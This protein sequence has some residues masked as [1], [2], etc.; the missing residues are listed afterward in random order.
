MR[1]AIHIFKKDVRHFRFEIALVISLV[2][3]FTLIEMR[4]AL[5]LLDPGTDEIAPLVFVLILLPISWWTL[6]G[7][8][9]HDEALAG[10]RQFW[11]TRPYSWRSL[12]VAKML[13]A[14]VFINFPMLVADG[15]ILRAYGFSV[16]AVLSGL[17][18][19]Q[20]LLIIVFLLPII[21]LSTL[22]R[23]FIQLIIAILA[24]W[25][26]VLTLGTFAPHIF[27]RGFAGAFVWIKIYFALLIISAAASAILFWQYS[28][29]GTAFARSL[30][31]A[32]GVLVVVGITLIPWTAGFRI[33]SWLS[34]TPANLS[35]AHAVLDLD[36]KGLAR[37]FPFRGG[38]NSVGVRI[39][40]QIVGL[41]EGMT[42]KIQNLSESF[43]EPDGTVWKTYGYSIQHFGETDQK[44]VVQTS[45]SGASYKKVVGESLKVH[46]SLYL[47]VFGNRQTTLVPFENRFIPVPRVGICSARENANQQNYFLICTSAFHSSTALVSF[48]IFQ[49][50]ADTTN[51]SWTTE[52]RQVGSYS[53]FPADPGIIPVTQDFMLSNALAPVFSNALAPVFSNVLAPAGHALVDTMEPLA[54]IRLDFEINN[55]RL[56]DYVVRR[57]QLAH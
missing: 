18:W 36:T 10:D 20:V 14:L 51:L 55:L 9:V 42:A 41:P 30:A 29:R 57:S 3:G 40:V 52:P 28:R 38:E 31:V 47:T 48:H 39:P 37:A 13:F 26:F 53:P 34:G 2:T 8:V 16:G 44:F 35:S 49:S 7:R 25:A 11:I 12:L 46:G 33:Q 19:S 24:P 22:T 27:L 17:I 54:Y 6:I 4:R 15:V 1:Q 32:A 45:L 56:S 23:G 43:E 5:W 50:S 21:A